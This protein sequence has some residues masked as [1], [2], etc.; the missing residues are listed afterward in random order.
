MLPSEIMYARCPG[1]RKH[2]TL[3][4]SGEERMI[5]EVVKEMIKKKAR[6]TGL[7]ADRGKGQGI[8]TGGRMEE[9]LITELQVLCCQIM[10]H[11]A[12]QRTLESCPH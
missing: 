9:Q 10:F 5:I 12:L 3:N 1:I 11:Q 2:P 8:G 4:S 6:G 7:T